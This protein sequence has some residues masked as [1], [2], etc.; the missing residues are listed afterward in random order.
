M[1]RE[2]AEKRQREKSAA[3]AERDTCAASTVPS[4]PSASRSEGSEGG[5]ILSH[6]VERYNTWLRVADRLVRLPAPQRFEPEDVLDEAYLRL[7][8]RIEK[9]GA[10]HI[11]NADAWFSRVLSSVAK[12]F[13]R[14]D[15]CTKRRAHQEPNEAD[16]MTPSGRDFCAPDPAAPTPLAILESKEVSEAL[17]GAL[18]KLTPE[19]RRAIIQRAQEEHKKSGKDFH[20]PAERS[21]TY[22]ARVHLQHVLRHLLDLAILLSM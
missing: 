22:R 9:G 2:P 5:A 13:R 14:R 1:P 19:A 15:S 18:R 6:L 21:R 16:P 8:H 4:S 12:D 3:A 11:E 17:W 20:P 10:P 7:L